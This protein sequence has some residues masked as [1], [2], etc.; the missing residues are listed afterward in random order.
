[1]NDNQEPQEPLILI[2][3]DNTN[4]LQMLGNLLKDNGY[5]PAAAQN[6]M[7]ALEFVQTTVPDLI[8]LDITMPKMDGIEVCRQMKERE[9]IK[10]IPV[11]FITSLTDTKDKIK[12]FQVGGVDYIT[13]PFVEA[14]VLAR[15]K[16]HLT[17]KKTLERLENMS[18]TDELTGVYNRRFAYE[19]LAKQIEIANR[20]RSGFVICYLDV[21]N[22]KKINDT[23][24]H[25]EGDKLINTVVNSLKRI[26]RT[27]DYIFRMG[28]DEFVLLFPKARLKD[29]DG[30]VGR[31]RE[32]LCHQQLHG[33]PIDFS[34][35]F[36]EF[37]ADDILSPDDIIKIADSSMYK[38][39]VKK[40]SQ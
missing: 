37:H 2:V 16:V 13:K 12:A 26:I 8:L 34:F 35:G 14:E 32:Q 7:A 36:A 24:G 25:A 1:M 20:E 21:D 5:K 23:Y 29:S 6:G 15:V 39:K 4:N 10:K 33:I 9:I 27:S 31:I 3:D 40:R 11:I 17:L 18:V 22:L 30:L 19:I 28:G 38:A